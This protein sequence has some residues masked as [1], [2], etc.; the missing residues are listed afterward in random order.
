MNLI[1]ISDINSCYDSYNADGLVLDADFTGVSAEAYSAP[2]YTKNWFHLGPVQLLDGDWG[3]IDYLSEY[4]SGDAS[5]LSRPAA[6][7]TMMRTLSRRGRRDALRTLR[8]TALRSE[9][10]AKDVSPQREKP[11]SVKETQNS[12]ILIDSP[13]TNT[14]I[15]ELAN[16]LNSNCIFFPYQYAARETMWE[17]GED[18]KTT[19]SFTGALDEY[20]QVLQSISIA[21]PRGKDPL[22][23]GQ[24]GN[25][26][27]YDPAESD[28]VVLN[29]SEYTY[30][31]EAQGLYFVDR[32][33]QSQSEENTGTASQDVFTIREN[34]FDGNATTNLLSHQLNYYDGAAFI[35]GDL[36]TLGSYGLLVRSE[37]LMVSQKEIILAYGDAIPPVFSEGNTPDWSEYPAEFLHELRDPR[38]GYVYYDGTGSGPHLEGYYATGDKLKYDTQTTG[39]PNNG[40]VMAKRNVYDDET[41]IVY[42]KYHLLPT[43]VIDPQRMVVNSLIDYRLLAPWQLT[44]PNENVTRT[45]FNALGLVTKIAVCGKIPST[46]SGTTEGDDLQTPGTTFTYDFF[47]FMEDGDPISVR[48]S[49]REHHVNSP[50]ISP[51]DEQNA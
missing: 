14:T 29:T 18:P 46:G 17:R 45:E 25:N 43:S 22:T 27:Y 5:I 40:L 23:G 47:A 11:Y 12:A 44:D 3:E 26:H 32:V 38:L 10:F 9:L 34:A 8:G 20:G 7:T 51:V 30:K 13:S 41:T 21:V 31:D 16:L 49:V 2:I 19:F 35:G 50:Y 24:L 39:Q 42:D 15:K 33:K 28:R 4:W 1:L 37:S 48:K 36:G 6:F